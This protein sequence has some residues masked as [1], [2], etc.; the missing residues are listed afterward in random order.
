MRKS[1]RQFLFTAAGTALA[2]FGGFAAIIA[3]LLFAYPAEP[4]INY[5]LFLLETVPGPRIVFDGGSSALY[6]IDP[7]EIE[8]HYGY[9]T[10]VIADHAGVPIEA[11]LTRIRHYAQK[12]DT[13]ILALEWPYYVRDYT[14]PVLARHGFWYFRHYLDAMPALPRTWFALSNTRPQDAVFELASRMTEQ[15]PPIADRV[16]DFRR[17]FSINPHGAYQD[18]PEKDFAGLQGFTCSQYIFLRRSRIIPGLGRIAEEM[19]SI[20]RD[21]AIRILI[22]WPAVA[23]PECY[24]DRA[25][26][27]AMAGEV[28]AA[29]ERAG[30]PVVGTPYR[31]SFPDERFRYDTFY[32]LTPEGSAIRTRHLIEDIDAAGILKPSTAPLKPMAGY[33]RDA[34]DKAAEVIRPQR[35]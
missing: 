7:P 27:D 2:V 10:I 23:G 5:R 13:F 26:V 30:I 33:V 3:T 31:S 29:F 14:E 6:A 25:R 1:E 12:G 24:A 21:K 18:R 16:A 11:K 8:K 32:H 19:A 35:P 15:Q 17:R 20:A 28:R 22:A 34:L 4:L 9:P